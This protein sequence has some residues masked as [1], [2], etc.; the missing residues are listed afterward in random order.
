MGYWGTDLYQNDTSL[1]VKEE[2]EEQLRKGRSVE[3]ITSELIKEFSCVEDELCEECAFWFA[4]ADTQWTWGVLLPH[5]KEKAL[6][7]LGNDGDM[8]CWQNEK[9]VIQLQRKRVLRDLQY[10]LESP[11]PPARKPIKRRV[12]KC[13]WKVG[14]VFAYRLE[15]ELARE[16][17][18]WGRY[19]LIQKVDEGVW[20]PGHIVPIVYIKLTKDENL[21]TSVEEYNCL[22]Y[23]QTSF[24]GYEDRFYPIDGR[25]PREDIAEKSQI[26][27][28]VDEFGLLPEFRVT[29]LNTSQ[30]VIPSNLI[31]VG[32]FIN[33]VPPQ[34]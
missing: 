4:L 13:Q 24:I 12:Y 28:E 9:L 7:L 8:A 23:V 25:R 18:L 32:N 29:L 27:Y 31:Y 19:F 2:F 22:E 6:Q 14:D 21:P 20:H 10:K 15:S 1:D 26:R 30:K 3:E 33:A 16:K 11:Q 34:K 5:V 17:G